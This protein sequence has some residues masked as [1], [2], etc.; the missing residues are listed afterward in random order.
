MNS[1]WH[2]GYAEGTK[3][4]QRMILKVEENIK[5]YNIKINIGKTKD[6]KINDKEIMRVKAKS[7]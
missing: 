6:I 4:L 1:I 5:E 7:E 3:L 2:D